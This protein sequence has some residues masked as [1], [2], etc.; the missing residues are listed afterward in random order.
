MSDEQQGTRRKVVLP[1]IDAALLPRALPRPK[2]RRQLKRCAQSPRFS[3]AL[4]L[5]DVAPLQ[6]RKSLRPPLA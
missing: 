1:P 3:V 5:L 4:Q 6:R 2:R